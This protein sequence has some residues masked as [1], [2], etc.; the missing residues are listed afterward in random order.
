MMAAADKL[1]IL[2][3][4]RGGHAAHPEQSVDAVLVAAQIVVA[5]QTIVSRNL[6]P[7]ETGVITVGS[8]QAGKAG[9][10][11]AETAE[12]LGS[13]RSFSEEVR[14]L[15][16]RRIREVAT[17]IAGALGATAEVTLTRGV[18]PTVNAPAPTALVY[19]IAKEVFGEDKVDTT[20]RTTGGEDFSA[21]L[22]AVPG[23]FFFLGARD[24]QRGF[25]FPHHNPRFDIDESC[26]PQ[27]V[28]I[29]CEAAVRAL[30]E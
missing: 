17:G 9:N 26:L 23:N 8:I 3:R 15:L 6:N 5:L 24:S 10:V 30:A 2:V 13:I 16:H 1:H 25:D 12:L 22:A 29:L 14:E 20:Y 19:D 27:G 28:A 7:E 4:G 18:D 11:I 21:V